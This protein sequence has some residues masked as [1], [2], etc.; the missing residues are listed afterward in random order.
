[1]VSPSHDTFSR[2]LGAVDPVAFNAAFMRFMAAF[3][4]Q[5]RI[6][7]PKDQVAIDGKSLRRAYAKGRA[8]MPPLMVTGLPATPS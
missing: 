7:V 3:G 2:V 5:T 4:E 6:D 8:R 1:M